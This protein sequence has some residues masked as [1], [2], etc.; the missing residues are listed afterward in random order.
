MKKKSNGENEREW[1]KGKVWKL[2]EKGG[3]EGE[4]KKRDRER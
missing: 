4:K 2:V 1:G 3:K